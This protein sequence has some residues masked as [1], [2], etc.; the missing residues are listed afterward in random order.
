MVSSGVGGRNGKEMGEGSRT[1]L[2]P[3]DSEALLKVVTRRAEFAVLLSVAMD[4][5]PVAYL[6]CNA[7]RAFSIPT[8]AVEV[9][10]RE[11]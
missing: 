10:V 9:G 5:C 2:S 8:A 11:R 3:L 6:S 7:V 4:M 1:F